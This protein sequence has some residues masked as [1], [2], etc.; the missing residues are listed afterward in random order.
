MKNLLKNRKGFTLAEILLVVAIIVIL[1]GATVIGV[2]SWVNQSQTTAHAVE[3]KS[4]AFEAEAV[5]KV[6]KAKGNVGSDP[7]ETETLNTGATEGSSQQSST[8]SSKESKTDP[9]PVDTTKST[10]ASSS[11]S[12]SESSSQGSTEWTEGTTKVIS[13]SGGASTSFST[14]NGTH[15]DPTKDMGYDQWGNHVVGA[16]VPDTTSQGDVDFGSKNVQSFTVKVTGKVLQYTCND[17]R[18]SISDNGDGTYTVTYTADQYRYN[19]PISKVNLTFKVD[20]DS[21]ANIKV[22][23]VTEYK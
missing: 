3:S 15:W 10:S 19:P 22:T 14:S 7:H 1:S 20:G 2:A 12:S 8:E 16:N 9:D 6:L 11:E 5:D 17:W 13:G 21:A 23:S 18:Y 4:A